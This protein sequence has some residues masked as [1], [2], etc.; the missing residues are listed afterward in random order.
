[1]EP[2]ITTTTTKAPQNKNWVH[3]IV[4]GCASLTILSACILLMWWFVWRNTNDNHNQTSVQTIPQSSPPTITINVLD[5]LTI[6]T[7]TPSPEKQEPPQA[8]LTKTEIRT[9][10]DN[11]PSDAFMSAN[12]QITEEYQ[13]C[14]VTLNDR[15]GN[16]RNGVFA[17][18]IDRLDGV[19]NTCLVYEVLLRGDGVCSVTLPNNGANGINTGE[20]IKPYITR[21]FKVPTL[22]TRDIIFLFLDSDILFY[23]MSDTLL[24]NQ[25]NTSTSNGNQIMSA[26]NVDTRYFDPSSKTPLS[27][28]YLTESGSKSTL[29]FR[30][31]GRLF[32]L[33][34][35]LYDTNSVVSI[36]LNSVLSTIYDRLKIRTCWLGGPKDLVSQFIS[37][38]PEW[39]TQIVFNPPSTNSNNL[40]FFKKDPYGYFTAQAYG[41]FESWMIEKC[42][43]MD[44]RAEFQ[45]L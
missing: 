10:L 27:G 11:L 15:N 24:K 32:V 40:S 5:E 23:D 8:S 20:Q 28:P 44:Q 9:F 43:P 26:Q 13:N 21:S 16:Y 42:A 14:N 17:G 30:I 25:Q 1:M 33:Q 7:P 18:S 3:V 29:Q 22:V 4:I 6:N 35:S 31:A 2:V 37:A 34:T 45:I 39:S 41:R 19:T 12:V 36:G 38:F